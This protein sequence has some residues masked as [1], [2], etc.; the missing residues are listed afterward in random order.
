MAWSPPFQP[1]VVHDRA[2]ERDLVQMRWGL[3][4]RWWS[5]PLKELRAATFNAVDRI[6]GADIKAR[7]HVV[8]GRLHRQ[9]VKPDDFGPCH[10]SGKAATHAQDIAA[11]RAAV[12]GGSSRA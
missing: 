7:R 11:C 9:P 4:P 6:G 10:F 8:R 12:A 5:K 2:G 3:V 1:D